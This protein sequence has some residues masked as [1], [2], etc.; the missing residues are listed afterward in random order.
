VTELQG[1]QLSLDAFRQRGC[2]V[3]AVVVDPPATNADLARTAAV[4]YPILADPEL[5]A[6]DAYG[7]RHAHGGPDGGDIAH[8]ASVL[9]DATGVVRW[10]FVTENVRVRPTPEEVL[11]AIDGL[12]L[13]KRPS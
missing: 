6:I 4:D 7:L 11:D 5:H 13:A 10:T 12:R 1:L 8:S 9:V 2:A 3:A